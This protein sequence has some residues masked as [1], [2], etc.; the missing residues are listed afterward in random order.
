MSDSSSPGPNPALLA[1]DP[2]LTWDLPL[3]SVR[4]PT[5]TVTKMPVLRSHATL[6]T[7]R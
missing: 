3:T 6:E 1:L 4:S 5:L 7:G 2:A